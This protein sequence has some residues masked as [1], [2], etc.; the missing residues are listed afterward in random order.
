MQE[1]M[2]VPLAAAC[3]VLD[4]RDVDAQGM[5]MLFIAYV[6]CAAA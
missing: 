2:S 1:V 6:C 4:G 3:G 5:V